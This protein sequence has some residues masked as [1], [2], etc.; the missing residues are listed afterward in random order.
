[1]PNIIKV[2]KTN[3]KKRKVNGAEN[4]TNNKI[5]RTTSHPPKIENFSGSETHCPPG[6][7]SVS[8]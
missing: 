7:I 8:V 3:K 5:P 2:N 6:D 1:M 4:K